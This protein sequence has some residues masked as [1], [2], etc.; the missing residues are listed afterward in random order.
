[1][2]DAPQGPSGAHKMANA[3]RRPCGAHN[4]VDSTH[5]SHGDL[6]EFCFHDSEC[7][8]TDL[9]LNKEQQR[10]RTNA[11]AQAAVLDQLWERCRQSME[12]QPPIVRDQAA[13]E[14]F[15]EAVPPAAEGAPVTDGRQLEQI[16]ETTRAAPPHPRDLVVSVGTNLPRPPVVLALQPT[17][18]PESGAHN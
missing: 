17:W 14:A 8:Y 15:I 2:A 7:S 16:L 4:M 18:P 10:E 12:M 1:M 11:V 3:S 5:R 13:K 6:S 9:G